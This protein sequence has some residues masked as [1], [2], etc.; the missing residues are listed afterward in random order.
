MNKIK[1][2]VKL[3]NIA[4]FEDLNTEFVTPSL[5]IGIY[6]NNGSGKTYISRMF[7]LLENTNATLSPKDNGDCPTDSL[8]KFG[9]S[10]GIFSFKVT[11]STG[12]KEDISVNLS[13]KS[14]PTIPNTQ[15]IYHTFNQDYIDDNIKE[16][17]YNKDGKI[18]GYILGRTNI[19][20]SDD[21]AKLNSIKNEGSLLREQTESDIS[22]YID[23]NINSIRDI[24]RIKEYDELLKANTILSASPIKTDTNK[25]L[26]ELLSAH[27]KIKSIPDNLE[28]IP[29]IGLPEVDL[30][31]LK[32]CIIELQ[33]EY[34]LSSFAQEFKNR[35]NGKRSFYENGVTYY[36]ENPN[37]CPFCGQTIVQE[38]AAAKLIDDYTTFLSDNES[39]TIRG[40][41]NYTA[42]IN[43]ILQSIN[44]LE[45]KY[46]Y[47]AL[48][49][50]Q[51]KTN[52]LP[53]F[54][55]PNGEVPNFNSIKDRLLSVIDVIHEKI[56]AIN[57]PLTVSFN[58]AELY[59]DIESCIKYCSD[60]NSLISDINLQLS[61]ANNESRRI[62]REICKAAYLEIRDKY[63]DEIKKIEQLRLDFLELEKQIK[64]KRDSI[65]TSKKEK[66]YDVIIKILNYFFAGKY[67]LDSDSF[68]LVFESRTLDAGQT[69]KVLSEGEK[70]IIAFSYYLGDAFQKIDSESDYSRLF[71]I[72]DDPI[73][74]M[75]YSH[76][77]TICGV[78]RDINKIY[79]DKLKYHK[80]IILTH[81]NDFM[82][83]LAANKIIETSLLL[84]NGN[85]HDDKINFTIPYVANLMDIY[86]I[87]K[88]NGQPS[89]STGNSIRYIIETLIKFQNINQSQKAIKTYIE[90]NFNDDI[91]TYTL[92]NDLS[93]GGWRNTQQPISANDYILL[94]QSLI[95]HI[96]SKFPNQI[97]YC[98]EHYSGIKPHYTPE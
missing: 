91:K 82:Q 67:T 51:Y 62:R 88:C 21:E 46:S 56:K 24:K 57:V 75:D 92:I 50:N 93:H 72:I 16:F 34:S 11:D 22:H 10:T 54:R 89:H 48:L 94:C 26:A 78:L 15:Y 69:Q 63:S 58:P 35:I 80:F 44:N 86:R 64:I 23:E 90:D 27:N 20:L 76:V 5:R 33:R 1:V 65:K 81:N 9:S 19:D 49:F 73:S 61:N 52:Y 7:R 85:I 43:S 55:G 40:F 17:G 84:E 30:S 45:N 29:G 31:M 79:D 39:N 2:S 87:A 13:L 53:S 38:S 83:I 4:P 66:V 59:S 25:T 70:R 98:Q 32:N 36:T 77:Y 42:S 41:N 6:A 3:Q 74:S 28:S 18:T 68:K 96:E 97:K 14:I 47:S 95:L 8:L 60:Y 71:F 37:V 12:V